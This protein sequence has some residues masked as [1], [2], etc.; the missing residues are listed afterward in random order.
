DGVDVSSARDR[1]RH[2]L[3]T[4]TA[5]L[6]AAAAALATLSILGVFRIL[7]VPG[8]GCARGGIVAR[9]EV[10]GAGAH[11]GDDGDD[12]RRH[13]P[14]GTGGS[15]GAGGDRAHR[16]EI[17]FEPLIGAVLGRFIYI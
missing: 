15:D 6:G 13:E 16:I 9:E 2:G 3:W 5:S 14:A 8:C 11:Q 17:F 10:P 7:A 4:A 12:D 1:G